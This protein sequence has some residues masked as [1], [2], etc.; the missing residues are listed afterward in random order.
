MKK[1]YFKTSEVLPSLM[2]VA[3]VVS[4]KNTLP[5]LGDILF[6]VHDSSTLVL[7][8]SDGET[9]VSTKTPIIDG[10]EGLSFC[11]DAK[12]ITSTLSSLSGRDVTLTLD[13]TSTVLDGKYDNGEFSLPFESSENYPTVKTTCEMDEKIVSAQSILNALTMTSCAIGH[14]ELRPIMNGVHI[15]FFEDCMVAASSDGHKLARYSDKNITSDTPDIK[16]FTVP[17]KPA[18][19]ITSMIQKMD[20]SIKI[21]FNEKNVVF[22]CKD[23]KV[24][25]RLLEGRFPNYNAVIPKDN[26]VI[27]IINREQIME[28]IK[29]V[30]PFGNQT[31]K[32]ISFSFENGKVTIG[33]ENIDFSKQAREI[34]DCK[35][36]AEPFVIGFNGADILSAMATI[37]SE[38][39]TLKMKAADRAVTIEPSTQGATCEYLFTLMPIKIKNV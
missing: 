5:I 4:P 34:V 11:I 37:Q 21:S 16:G 13:E 26:A 9:W 27:A 23:F 2:Q 29:R 17:E 20:D 3:K 8:A 33:A 39:A 24:V 18:K 1:L 28:T 38:T 19:M 36:D 6:K 31:F 25:S 15:D 30:M 14:D 7:T 12:D 10:D 22:S 32:S 35:F